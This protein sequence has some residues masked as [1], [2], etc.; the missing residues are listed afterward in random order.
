MNESFNDML[1]RFSQELASAERNQIEQELWDEYGASICVLAIDMSGFTRLTQKHGVVHYL[2]MIRRM[3]L[4]A[5]PIIESYDGTVVKFE[6]DNAF[7]YFDR[8]GNA[9]RASISLNLAM[10]SANILTPD[11]LDLYVSCGIDFG[12]CLI[13][14][15]GD[16]FGAP[17]NMASK[18]GE[19][20]GKAGQILVT[21]EAME[22]VPESHGIKTETVTVHVAGEDIT[23]HSV[24]F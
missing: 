11:E 17:V 19:D 12:K 7:A 20:L 22:L 23:V 24:Q 3:Q 13:P 2:S 16:F 14:H 21:E 9:I 5:R 18:L 8:P 1:L 4:T 10:N 6:A 15:P